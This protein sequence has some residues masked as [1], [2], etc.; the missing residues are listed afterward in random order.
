V[1]DTVP[2]VTNVR[3]QLNQSGEQT[4]EGDKCGRGRKRGR[5]ESC[6]RARRKE[7][8]RKAVCLWPFSLR[9]CIGTFWLRKRQPIVMMQTGPNLHSAATLKPNEQSS[10]CLVQVCATYCRFSVTK[11]HEKVAH[12]RQSRTESRWE[13]VSGRLS[14]AASWRPN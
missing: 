5:G 2:S 9:I 11:S 12:E 8:K 7:K 1:F 4:V 3:V 13:T 10:L 6:E 14:Q